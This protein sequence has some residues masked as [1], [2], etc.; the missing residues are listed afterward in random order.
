MWLMRCAKK[1]KQ[2]TAPEFGFTSMCSECFTRLVCIFC[3]EKELLKEKKRKRQE[4]FQEQK[5]SFVT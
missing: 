1:H 5:V 4:L 2:I 3:R